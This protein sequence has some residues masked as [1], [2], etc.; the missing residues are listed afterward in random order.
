LDNPDDTGVGL[1]NAEAAF[2]ALEKL[3][4]AEPAKN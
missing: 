3:Y 2:Q 4:P 1:L